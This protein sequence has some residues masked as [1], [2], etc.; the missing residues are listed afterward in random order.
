MK[1]I[2]WVVADLILATIVA[3]LGNIVAA[4][5]Q[6]R[7]DLTDPVRFA[8]VAVVFVVCL[9]L[10]LLVTLRRS[11]TAD[12]VRTTGA[13]KV[14]DRSVQTR[15]RV[16]QLKGKLTGVAAEEIT[17]GEAHVSQTI[18]TV[19]QSG[20]AVGFEAER[21]AGGSVEVEQHVDKVEKG[22]SATGAR[23]R[24]LE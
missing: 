15:E 14:G 7:F 5:L 19:A 8:F 23:I 4:Y 20:E 17:G 2:G 9:A 1:H 13:N 22:G 12:G 24:K 3:I 6:E 16:G 18:G 21:Q 10:L 11:N